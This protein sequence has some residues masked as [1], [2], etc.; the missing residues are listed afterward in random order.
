MNEFIVQTAKDT[1]KHSEGFIF[2]FRGGV[3][4][5]VLGVSEYETF[6]LNTK[7]KEKMKLSGFDSKK[8]VQDYWKIF[9][10]IDYFDHIHRYLKPRL[11]SKSPAKTVL[12]S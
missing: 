2:H 5:V 3:Y 1:G 4:C 11:A 8:N 12:S 7:N 6:C 10:G 9:C